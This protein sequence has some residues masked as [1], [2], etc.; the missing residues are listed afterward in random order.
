[1]PA[2]AIRLKAKA[3]DLAN[4]S[5]NILDLLA[6]VRELQQA[7]GTVESTI[8]PQQSIRREDLHLQRFSGRL[9]Y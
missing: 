9:S 5:K 6:I 8:K 2:E 3:L 7:F 1:M 4:G